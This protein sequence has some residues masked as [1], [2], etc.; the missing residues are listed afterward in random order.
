[1]Y[2]FLKKTIKC[3]HS[4]KGVHVLYMIFFFSISLNV[5]FI[6][7]KCV[8]RQIQ[9]D[10][11]YLN[12]EIQD[13]NYFQIVVKG[14]MKLT[15]V[16]FRHKEDSIKNDWYI[17]YNYVGLS[18][19]ALYHGDS[20]VIRYL[21]KLA[22]SLISNDNDINYEIKSISQFPMGICFLNLYKI[23]KNIKWKEV[24]DKLYSRL[25]SHCKAN[26]RID[27]FYL[28]QS[29]CCVDLLGMVVPFLIE[30]YNT[31]GNIDAYNIAI[32]N[33]AIYEKYLIDCK[34]GIPCHEFDPD[35]GI[36]KGYCNW[37]RGIGW[38]LLALAYCPELKR[39]TLLENISKL[40]YKQYP[41]QTDSKYDT[42]VA[43][44][45]EIF[46]KS[47]LPQ[48]KMVLDDIKEKTTI[49]GFIDGSSGDTAFSGETCIAPFCNGFLL[50]LVTRFAQTQ[51]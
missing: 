18:Y 24:S 16:L 5:Y 12:K 10:L 51:K 49:D 19:W 32:S 8:G 47:R 31:T 38:Y 41:L 48:R 34:T 36:K 26:G 40:D 28:D 13:S 27:Y 22:T 11:K 1:M 20:T 44:L 29:L 3:M 17:N 7:T 33:I 9:P 46:K 50:M 42:S 21:E 14:G 45:F 23:T 25:V 2:S 39:D 15:P 30:Y 4:T 43:L 37:G 35:T 6:H